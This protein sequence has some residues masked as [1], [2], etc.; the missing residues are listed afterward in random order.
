M[1]SYKDLFRLCAFPLPVS[2]EQCFYKS[3]CFCICHSLFT[4]KCPFCYRIRFNYCIFQVCE[5]DDLRSRSICMGLYLPLFPVHFALKQESGALPR[6]HKRTGA[7]HTQIRPAPVI[8]I[9]AVLSESSGQPVDAVPA[10]HLL[11]LSQAFYAMPLSFCTNS[12][13]ISCAKS[14]ALCMT[15]LAVRDSLLPE[16]E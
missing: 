10:V 2:W 9:T 12:S 15:L 6:G 13:L 8:K 14:P 11:Y 1:V 16:K 5:H 7:G 3:A 4:S